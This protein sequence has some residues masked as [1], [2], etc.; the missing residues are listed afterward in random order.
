MSDHC[1][2]RDEDPGLPKNRPPPPLAVCE[3][4]ISFLLSST[5][6]S[7]VSIKKRW[8]GVSNHMTQSVPML[9]SLCQERDQKVYRLKARPLS[10]SNFCL[11]IPLFIYWKKSL[12]MVIFSINSNFSDS[13]QDAYISKILWK[14]GAVELN[15]HYVILITDCYERG[16][17][18]LAINWEEEAN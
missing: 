14:L 3:F 11:E 5:Q 16:G 17:E 15:H 18:N 6:K 1:G 12:Y 8:N 10:P 9:R 2:L 4:C 7:F 13:T